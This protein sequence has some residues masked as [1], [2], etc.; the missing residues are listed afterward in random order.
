[1]ALSV[2]LP[3]DKGPYVEHY[4]IET[5]GDAQLRLEGSDNNFHAIPML[6]AHYCQ[7]W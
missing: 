4:L 1:M 5:V 7:C 2:R 3:E 6:V